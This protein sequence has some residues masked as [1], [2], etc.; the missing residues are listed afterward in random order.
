MNIATDGNGL[1]PLRRR[2]MVAN[3]RIMGA[4]LGS[5]IATIMMPHIASISTKW[6]AVQPVAI[7]IAI[8]GM[9]MECMPAPD[10]R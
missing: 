10:R 6:D 5:I 4:A 1:V 7:G 9:D 2:S 3:S 8:S